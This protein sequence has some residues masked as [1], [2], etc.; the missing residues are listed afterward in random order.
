[1]SLHSNRCLIIPDVHQDIAWVD[2]IFARETNYD[3]VVFLGDYFDGYLPPQLGTSAADTCAYLDKKRRELGDRVVF[4]LG[5][6]DIQ[7]L[8]SKPACDAHRTPRDLHYHCGAAFSLPIARQVA[9]NLSPEFWQNAR[10][11]ADVNGWLL[12][13]AG[14]ARTFWPVRTD[15]AESLATLE[16]I[17]RTALRT[18]PEKSSPLLRAGQMRSG[19][20]A[21]GGITWLDWIFEF[22]DNLPCPQIVGHTASPEGARQNGRSWCLD[23]RQ[24]NYGVLTAEGLRIEAC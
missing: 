9:K 8:E 21:V 2:K 3:L 16:D 19:D 24:T 14:V 20:Q 15:L 13:H 1:M 5:N 10:L 22:E 17:C 11:F 12:S 4:L 6:H 23:G 7:Y 18:I